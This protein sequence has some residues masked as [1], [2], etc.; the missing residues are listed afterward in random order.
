MALTNKI[1]G[2]FFWREAG[3]R[4]FIEIDGKAV[5]LKFTLAQS[6]AYQNLITEDKAR[7]KEIEAEVKK[8]EI[9]SAELLNYRIKRSTEHSARVVEIALNP[10]S[11]KQYSHDQIVSLFEEQLDLL[12]IV[13]RTW[14]DKK[15]FNPALDSILDPHL[16]P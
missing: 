12:A 13:A 1:N 2:H 16:A 10:K 15:V 3:N 7:A 5:E 14:V 4:F 9:G 8:M 11:D 6:E